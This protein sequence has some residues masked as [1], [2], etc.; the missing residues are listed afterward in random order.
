MVKDYRDTGLF[1]RVGRVGVSGMGRPTG[2]VAGGSY[3]RHV[4]WYLFWL[5]L[6]AP[7]GGNVEV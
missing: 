7:G 6:L 2:F 4:A 5:A 3:S 1:P